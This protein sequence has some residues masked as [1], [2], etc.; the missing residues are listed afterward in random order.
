MQHLLAFFSK[1]HEFLQNSVFSL[2]SACFVIFALGT[3]LLN[4][5]SKV[6]EFVQNSVFSR[7]SARFNIFALG[8][9][10]FTDF[11][12]RASVCPK[13]RFLPEVSTFPYVFALGK[14][15]LSD[16][17][18]SGRLCSKQ[19]FQPEISTYWALHFCTGCTNFLLFSAKC[20]ISAK[21]ATLFKTAFL[22]R[23]QHVL[24]FLHWV[25]HFLLFSAKCT[26]L[27]KN[28]NSVI[29]PRSASTVIFPLCTPLFNSFQ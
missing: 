12:Q 18:Q 4:V 13:Q 8:A 22:P 25:H 3:P 16:Y 6:H 24:S 2:R 20:T 1:V 10:L 9:P 29:S 26:S 5:F 17:L 19:R 28:Q 27:S 14:L 23:D 11:Q 7:K 21:W 15:L